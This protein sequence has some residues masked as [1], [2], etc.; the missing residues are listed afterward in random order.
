MANAN[1]YD[2]ETGEI[3]TD[4]VPIDTAALSAI[5]KAEIDTQVATAHR[6]PRNMT[7]AIQNVLTLTT[8]DEETAE[9]AIYAL[10]RGGK[11]IR[12]ASIRLAEA[13]AQ[14]WGNCRVDARVIMVNRQEKTVTAEGVFHDLETNMA[15]RATVQRR[16]VDRHG[17]IYNDDMIIVTGNAACAIARRNAILAGIPRPVWRKAYLEAERIVAGDVTTLVATRDKAISSLAHY[18]LTPD[19]IF[20]IIGVEGADDIG[21]SHI[22]SLRGMFA[23]LKNSETTVE[24]L[25]RTSRKSAAVTH[26][27]VADPLADAAPEASQPAQKTEPAPATDPAAQKPTTAPETAPDTKKPPAAAKSPETFTDDQ[28]ASMMEYARKRASAGA[29]R[30]VPKDIAG[31]EHAKIAEQWLQE[32]DKAVSAL[33]Q[34]KE[35]GQ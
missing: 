20:Q 17:R 13:A 32:F 25:L 6:F 27:A 33:A 30:K 10:P 24:E 8:M 23:G 34:D 14:A 16:I 12:G 31:P 11:P 35:A 21:I 4:L 22:P 26:E 5:T 18:G 7:R 9:E 1:E 15:T 19:Q 29:A 3:T 28:I 2:S